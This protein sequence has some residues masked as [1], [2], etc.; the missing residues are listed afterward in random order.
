[1]E[2]TAATYPEQLLGL[3]VNI[4]DADFVSFD[5]E[6]T[7]IP[8]HLP[9]RQPWKS[10]GRS[11]LQD[12][13]AE[14]KEA[15]G[16]YQILQVGITCGRFDYLENKYI[17]RPY[18][19]TL[20]PLL[21]ERLDIDREICIQSGAATFLLNN[22]FDMGAPFAKG[23]QYLSR[24]EAKR[25]QQMAYDRFDKKNL[26]E[27]VLLKV[28]EK[29]SIDFVRRAREAIATW[30]SSMNASGSLE[31][32]THTGLPHSEVHLMPVISRFEKRLIHQLVRAEF[33]DLVSMGRNECMRIIRFDPLREAENTKR[34]RRRVNESIAR[35]TGF[36]WIFE[37]LANGDI[38]GADPFH[39]NANIIAISHS[40][41]KDRFD[42]THER[43]K[44][45]QPVLVGHNMFTD[46][47][48]FYRSFVGELPDT[49]D[50]FCEALHEVFPR[51]I[52]TKW[53][54][55]HAGGDLNASP[56]LQD[57]A[58]SIEDQPLPNISECQS[59]TLVHS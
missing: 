11:T 56:T 54:A 28:E 5:L 8:S 32:T 55:T 47:V 12:R 44:K 19:I 3:L 53:L 7:G 27:D 18:N 14:T 31:I 51:I 42:R 16:R 41:V 35:Q 29:D 40:D 59:M 22:G 58:E 48:Y 25:A 17:L 38:S 52:D 9:N 23:V 26:V 2:V 57:I 46:L 43:L 10:G 50:G 36:R 20:S 13:Y 49:L 6:L 21:E 24:E 37:A 39:S 34:L 45:H 1:M 30:R 33:P 15:A 4:S